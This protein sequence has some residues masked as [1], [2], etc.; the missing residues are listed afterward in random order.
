M[1]SL[2]WI[3]YLP[4]ERG[5]LDESTAELLGPSIANYLGRVDSAVF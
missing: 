3:A 4:L 1:L 5:L 2:E